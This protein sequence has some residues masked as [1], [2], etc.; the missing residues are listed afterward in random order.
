MAYQG[1]STG[2]SPNDNTGDSLLTG[3]VKINSNFGEIYNALGA[4]SG[5]IPVTI[6]VS[7][8]DLIFSTGVGSTSFKLY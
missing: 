1:I 4:S 8:T 7:G 5:T 3:A 6:S 2:T